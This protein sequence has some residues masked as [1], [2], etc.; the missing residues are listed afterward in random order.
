[1][2]RT[3][4]WLEGPPRLKG[5]YRVALGEL[6]DAAGREAF[7]PRKV[8]TTS[9][10]LGGKS[11]SAGYMDVRK[12][13]EHVPKEG[14]DEYNLFNYEDVEALLILEVGI[15]PAYQRKGYGTLLV[16]RAE[17]IAQEWGL[18]TVVIDNIIM[19]E[20][21][22]GRAEGSSVMGH[23]AA[24]LGYRLFEDGTMAVKR[25]KSE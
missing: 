23:I 19:D 11:G 12:S 17:E 21:P 9:Y 2:K 5:A 14:A 7:N 1:M 22:Y 10:E 20:A 15:E 3:E 18:V 13:M 16:K 8:R 25:L 6:M 4:F 24:G